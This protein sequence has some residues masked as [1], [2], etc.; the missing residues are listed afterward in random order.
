MP[1]KDPIA[2][3][4]A[5][6]NTEA[7]VVQRFLESLGVEAFAVED[8]SLVGHWMFGNL[9]EI[10]KPQVWINRSDAERAA[11]LLTEF[12]RGKT[13]RDAERKAEEPKTITAQCEDCG[14]STQF[15]GSLNGTVQDCPHC[16]SFVDVGEIDWPDNNTE[17]E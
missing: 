13:E 4:N 16:G 17:E 14:K 5:A 2:A 6:S 1:L 10:H 15:P 7:A 11:E 12:E 3:Y 8:N 9:P